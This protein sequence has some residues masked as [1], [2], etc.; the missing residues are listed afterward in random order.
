MSPMFGMPITLTATAIGGVII[1]SRLG[2]YWQIPS[3]V[4]SIP[5]AMCAA[6]AWRRAF[7]KVQERIKDGSL[8]WINRCPKCNGKMRLTMRGYKCQD[9]LHCIEQKPC[10]TWLET[11]NFYAMTDQEFERKT[12]INKAYFYKHGA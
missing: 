12:N 4:V 7:S 10:S 2:G 11:G 8:Q 1:A 6:E 3:F 5:V 9:C